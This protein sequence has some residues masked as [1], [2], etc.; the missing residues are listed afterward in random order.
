[1][2]DIWHEEKLVQDNPGM[3]ADAEGGD[4]GKQWWDF[5]QM[6]QTIWDR[7]EIPMQMSCCPPA[8]KGWRRLRG[9]GLLDLYWK[10]VEKIMVHRMGT[11]DFH[12]CLHGGMPK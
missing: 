1:M 10:V 12:P 9:I 3:T 2:T 11:I 5:V 4:L 6:I 7:G 8:T